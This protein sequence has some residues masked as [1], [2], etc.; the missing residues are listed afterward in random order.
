[1]T[2]LPVTGRARPFGTDP[3]PSIAYAGDTRRLFW[4]A[5]GTLLLT[6]VT[7]GIYRFWATAR[8]RRY[9]W[10]AIRV[11]GQPLEFTGTGLEMLLG[12]LITVVFLAIYLAVFNLF[13]AFVGMAVFSNLIAVNLSVLAV[14]P[15]LSY[16]AYRARRY[17]LS[18]TRL[19]GIRFGLEKGAVDYLVRALLYGLVAVMTLGV[20]VPWMQFELR[21][22]A[23]DRTRFGSLRFRL[24][25]HWTGFLRSWAWVMAAALLVA[26]GAAG[27]AFRPDRPAL[28]VVAVIGALAT[29]LAFFHHT[30]A[31]FRYAANHTRLGQ[32][33]RFRSGVRTG[34]VLGIYVVGV[35][36]LSI[37]GGIVALVV[38]A[39]GAGLL[40]ALGI[41]AGL[42][43]LFGGRPGTL[44]E[45]AAIGAAVVVAAAYVGALLATTAAAQVLVTQPILEHYVSTLSLE[46]GAELDSALQR[47]EDRMAEAGGLADALDVGAAF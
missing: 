9:Y 12:F 34:R 47:E 14:L 13:L 8:L 5:L 6:V 23:M 31:C 45:A 24:E 26:V 4:L 18:R 11:Q 16:A 28:I 38:G 29:G 46:G 30:I 15:L 41:G 2:A 22:F 7:L 10:S 3:V 27:L 42:G 32:T 35:I 33:I 36:L 44:S 43:D 40:G 19:R 21:R 39:V 1:M 37:I 25:G 17:L 20:M